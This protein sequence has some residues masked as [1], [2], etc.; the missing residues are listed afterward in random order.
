MRLTLLGLLQDHRELLTPSVADL[1]GVAL[2]GLLLRLLAA[3]AEPVPKDL[4]DMLGVVLD[5]EL[6]ADHLGDSPGTPEGVGPAVDLGFLEQEGCELLE[7]LIRQSDF[8]SGMWLGSQPL[9]CGLSQSFPAIQRGV[10]NAQ[11]ASDEG[12]RFSLVH[13]LDSPSATTFQFRC[14]SCRSHPSTTMATAGWFLWQNWV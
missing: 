1:L 5:A 8:G 10:A 14:G 11:D 7:L 13:Q 6:A 12:A 2:L 4:T 9:R 3:P